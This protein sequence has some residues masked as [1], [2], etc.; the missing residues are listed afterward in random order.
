MAIRYVDV[1]PAPPRKTAKAAKLAKARAAL[2]AVEKP[3]KKKGRWAG[4][5]K[6]RPCGKSPT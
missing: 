2:D 6:P 1:E 5:A 3:V 4:K